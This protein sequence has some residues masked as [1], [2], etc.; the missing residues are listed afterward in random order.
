MIDNLS[1]KC[2]L[3]T[4][5]NGNKDYPVIGDITYIN[6]DKSLPSGVDV[7][8]TQKNLLTNLK[9][10]YTAFTKTFDG[11]G[12]QRNTF[13]EEKSIFYREINNVKELTAES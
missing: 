3:T 1:F 13:R 9:T 5:I 10:K 2:G 6:M 12:K 7:L 4:V 8:V 11:E